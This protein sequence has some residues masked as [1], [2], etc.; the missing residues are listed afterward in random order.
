MQISIF[1]HGPPPP[2]PQPF[3]LAAHVLR[4]A[5]DLPGKVALSVLGPGGADDWTFAR[6]EAAVG[7]C[8]G[9]MKP[10]DIGLDA[11]RY[12]EAVAH[13]HEIRDR[14]SFLDLAAHTGRLAGFA[15]REAAR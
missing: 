11:A 10:G 1:D 7:A 14:F 5:P 3:N 13:A 9:P 15:E 2:C 8:D 4:R 6:L 12:G